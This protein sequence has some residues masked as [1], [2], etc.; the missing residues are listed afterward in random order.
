MHAQRASLSP[1]SASMA[2]IDPASIIN[3]L[4]MEEVINAK[5][6]FSAAAAAWIEDC[7]GLH[8]FK[9][10]QHWYNASY[11]ALAGVFT[12]DELVSLWHKCIFSSKLDDYLAE[13]DP[14]VW[15][16]RHS[17]WRYG[18]SQDYR[19]F[20]VCYNGFSCLSVD[21]PDF[22]VHLTHTR[23]I[24]TAAW[25]AHGR[26]NPIYL[27]APFGVLLYFQKKHV[28]TIGFAL[29]A[30][31]VLVAQVQLRQKR[32]NRFLYK[33]PKNYIEFGLDLVQ[34]AFPEESLYLVTG[35]S[36]S[37]A[38]RAAYCKEEGPSAETL[39]RIVRFYDQPLITYARTSET[40]CGSSDDGRRFVRLRKKIPFTEIGTRQYQEARGCPKIGGCVVAI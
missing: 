21:I 31:G 32:G 14:L 8:Y 22:E 36:T 35:A 34:R 4:S 1:S 33:L 11:E 10:D 15:K 5:E 13:Q 25:A 24:N 9:W 28:M 26:D 40:V 16:V 7:Y 27:D 19:R 18:C 37:A 23:S 20:V 2:G 17:F 29:A 39:A 30:Q 12:R 3:I 6:R 38:I